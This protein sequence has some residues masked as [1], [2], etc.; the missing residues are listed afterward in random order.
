MILVPL[1]YYRLMI[2]SMGRYIFC[3]QKRKPF[4]HLSGDYVC[5]HSIMTTFVM[6]LIYNTIINRWTYHGEEKIMLQFK[7]KS[8]INPIQTYLDSFPIYRISVL[9]ARP[10]HELGSKPGILLN[11]YLPGGNR[12]C[13]R[14]RAQMRNA[15]ACS[16]L[17]QDTREQ[18]K[19]EGRL[20]FRK[21]LIA[22]EGFKR[23]TTWWLWRGIPEQVRL[24]IDEQGSGST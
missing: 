22:V 1:H 14:L 10:Q 15:E 8:S 7:I 4:E 19:V 3:G 6:I 2:I 18:L 13:L 17:D 21:L 5:L 9:P 20:D 24:A 16:P 23:A 11:Y 12:R